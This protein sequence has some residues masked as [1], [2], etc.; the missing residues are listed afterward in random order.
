MALFIRDKDARCVG[1]TNQIC[2][3][4]CDPCR[5]KI[6]NASEEEEEHEGGGDM[7]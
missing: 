5:G 2:A 1:F 7:A 4:L 3:S 6:Y